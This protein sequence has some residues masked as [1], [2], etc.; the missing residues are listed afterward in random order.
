MLVWVMSLSLVTA[1][2]EILSNMTE[3]QRKAVHNLYERNNNGFT[4]FEEFVIALVRPMLFGGG[5]IQVDPWCRMYVGIE[6][7]GYTHT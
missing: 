3:A 4:T 2:Q 7:D 6:P 5:A 1:S